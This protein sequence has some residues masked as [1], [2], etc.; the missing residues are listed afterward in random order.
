MLQ[1][2][3]Q[4]WNLWVLE[5]LYSAIDGCCPLSDEQGAQAM[6]RQYGLLGDSLDWDEPHVRPPDRL[7]DRF[8]VSRIGLVPLKHRV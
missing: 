3:A 2:S 5:A 4:M 6:Q 7:A 1:I 8:R